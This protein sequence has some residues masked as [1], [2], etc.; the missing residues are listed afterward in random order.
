LTFP[1]D[2]YDTVTIIPTTVTN[3][4]WI[5]Q[6]DVT[7]QLWSAVYTWATAS[8]RGANIYYFTHIGNEGG[9]QDGDAG[10]SAG[11]PQQAVVKSKSPNNLDLYDASGNVWQWCFDWYPGSIGSIRVYRG[12]SWTVGAGGQQLGAVGQSDPYGWYCG[13]GFRLVKT[14]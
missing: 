1:A 13:L 5:A 10:N 4:Y 3:A 12:G 14:Q 6:T 11:G 9:G 7:Y 2:S 8:A